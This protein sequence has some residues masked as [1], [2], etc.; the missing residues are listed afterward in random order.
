MFAAIIPSVLGFALFSIKTITTWRK[1]VLAEKKCLSKNSDFY[2]S[3]LKVIVFI[4]ISSTS[5]LLIGALSAD[6]IVSNDCST[7]PIY[8]YTL[9]MFVFSISSISMMVN[10]GRMDSVND[11]VRDFIKEDVEKRD[12]NFFSHLLIHILPETANIQAIFGFYL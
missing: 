10:L 7:A 4:L 3:Q 8:C 9:S 6:L 5:L 1:E 12:I 11:E 2:I